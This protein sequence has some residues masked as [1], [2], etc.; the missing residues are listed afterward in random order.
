M[1]AGVRPPQFQGVTYASCENKDAPELLQATYSAAMWLP[2]VPS[3]HSYA[4]HED[5]SRNKVTHLM[6]GG[7]VVI[8]WALAPVEQYPGVVMLA[9]TDAS[10]YDVVAEVGCTAA[11]V[12]QPLA[13]STTKD[14]TDIKHLI[15]NG[16]SQTINVWGF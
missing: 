1:R 12:I 11:P 8:V 9:I 6:V 2:L 3:R 14:E 16:R 15:Q 13:I 5:V 7:L 10:R 4:L